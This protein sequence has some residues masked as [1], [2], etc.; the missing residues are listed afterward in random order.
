[1]LFLEKKLNWVIT[2]D[3]TAIVIILG[4]VMC[5]FTHTSYLKQS[6]STRTSFSAIEQLQKHF[7]SAMPC[8]SAIHKLNGL[9]AN[10]AQ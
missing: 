6:S 4:K 7:P 5:K 9:F 10:S 1:M 3:V 8:S 2:A